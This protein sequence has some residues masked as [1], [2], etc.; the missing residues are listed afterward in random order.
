[1]KINSM[2]I[3]V[4]STTGIAGVFQELIHYSLWTLLPN[5]DISEYRIFVTV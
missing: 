4:K 1:M 2:E 3:Y 5:N